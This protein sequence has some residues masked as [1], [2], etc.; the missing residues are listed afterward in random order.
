MMDKHIKSG[1]HIS[2]ATIPVNAEDATGFG[3]LKTDK[4]GMI[5]TFIEKPS[6]DVLH[7]WTSEVPDAIKSQ[8]RQYL[9]SMGI[10][11]FNRRTLI[12]LFEQHLDAKDF[13]KEIIP[14]AIESHLKVASYLYDGYWTDIGT[15][16]SF[17]DA[18]LELTIELP[19]FDIYNEGKLIF[20]RSRLLPASKIS[21]TTLERTIVAEGS[22]IEASRIEHTLV[23]IRSRVGK[24]TTI[25]NTII[26]GND[27]YPTLEELKYKNGVPPIGIGQ[28]CYINNAIIDKNCRIGND[29]RI[30][31]G[32]HL[33]DGH[34]DNYS[35]VDGIVVIQKSAVLRDG[36]VI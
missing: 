24:G 6:A 22:I 11:I 23:G 18:N 13:G 19:P 28:R 25:A 21:G 34:H 26:M 10:Y 12:D 30:N 14:K 36:T 5:D 35:V 27:F 8:G 16:K 2:I 29:V 4:K 7:E 9:A 20:T 31:G 32:A 1:A 33:Q 17:F 3:I 15:I